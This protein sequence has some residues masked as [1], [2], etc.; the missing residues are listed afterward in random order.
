MFNTTGGNFICRIYFAFLHISL[1]CQRYQ[2]Y[3]ITG[4][5]YWFVYNFFAESTGIYMLIPFTFCRI[6]AHAKHF[7]RTTEDEI[8]RVTH[9]LQYMEMIHCIWSSKLSRVW[10]TSS[11]KCTKEA[12]SCFAFIPFVQPYIREVYILDRNN[13][14]D[15]DTVLELS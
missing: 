9:D 6:S 11:V 13:V 12:A 7:S 8:C 15:C 4:K 14:T 10:G 1:Y 3:I 2:L 5:L